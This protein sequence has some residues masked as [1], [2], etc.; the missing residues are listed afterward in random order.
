M[1]ITLGNKINFDI[2]SY[3][4][5]GIKSDIKRLRVSDMSQNRFYNQELFM[6]P[7]DFAHQHSD[8]ENFQANY[9]SD[10]QVER[11]ILIVTSIKMSDS[12]VDSDSSKKGTSTCSLASNLQNS[13]GILV[14]GRKIYLLNDKA[15][16]NEILREARESRFTIH[17]GTTK[18]YSD[19]KEYYWWPNIK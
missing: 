19:L 1:F 18:M 10:I 2:P 13:K 17:P 5:W 8:N 6:K 7:S 14:M 11:T 3:G 15:L 12:F 16:K 9:I 4:R